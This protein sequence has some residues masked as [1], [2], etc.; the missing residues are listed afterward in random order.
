MRQAS[1]AGG[2][3]GCKPAQ[4]GARGA[5]PARIQAAMQQPAGSAR[6]RARS[7]PLEQRAKQQ[8]ARGAALDKTKKSCKDFM[9]AEAENI[10]PTKSPARG[11]ALAALLMVR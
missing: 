3:G 6:G 11:I 1:L 4:R 10:G 8:G 7:L 5:A 2:L 9:I